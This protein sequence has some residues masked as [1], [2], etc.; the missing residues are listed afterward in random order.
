M[1]FIFSTSTVFMA[2]ELRL[3][4]GGNVILAIFFLVVVVFVSFLESVFP[5]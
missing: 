2:V 1:S 4:F 5:C 3:L